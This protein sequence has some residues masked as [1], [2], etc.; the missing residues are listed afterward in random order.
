MVHWLGDLGT[1]DLNIQYWPGK[2]HGN[3]DALSRS[4]CGDCKHCKKQEER[5]QL[6]DPT[7]CPARFCAVYAIQK[8]EAPWLTFYSSKDLRKWQSE[9]RALSKLVKWLQQGERPAWEDVKQESQLVRT[10]WSM[11]KSVHLNNE[12]I[13]RKDPN[14][15]QIQLIIP[16]NLKQQILRQVCNHCLGRHF[17]INKIL[18]NVYTR[19][20]WPGLPSQCEAMVPNM[21]CMSE[22]E[23]EI[24]S[25][26]ATPSRSGRITNGEDSDG[27]SVI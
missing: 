19:F 5:D 20:W 14:T 18:Y 26:N 13:Y 27:C 15:E 2:A 17:G 16:V 3:S 8:S 6:Q 23:S 12:V 9:D 21:Y 10:Y 1:Y 24:R 11:W 7:D 25:Q 22:T 4:P